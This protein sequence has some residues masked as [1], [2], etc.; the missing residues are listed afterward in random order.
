M[1]VRQDD[2]GSEVPKLRIDA[3]GL[4]EAFQKGR[5]KTR[6]AYLKLHNVC[7]IQKKVT[8]KNTIRTERA[9]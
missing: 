7:F 4:P 1:P 9:S 6:L 3:Y 2:R 8:Q 5:Y